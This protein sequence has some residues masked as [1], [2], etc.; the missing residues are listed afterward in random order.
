MTKLGK[1]F[2]S[3]FDQNKVR[4]RTF[5]LGGHTFKVLI[6]LTS[7]YEAMIE[8]IKVAD[9][10]S[11]EKYYAELTKEFVNN[12]DEIPEELGVVFTEDDVLIQNRSMR[13]AAKNKATTENRITEFF[14]LLVPEI[15]DFD[16]NSITYEDIDAEFPFSVQLQ[17]IEAISDT[18]SPNYK[19]IRGKSSGQSAGK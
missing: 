17:I 19:D 11:I 1:A 9:D 8:R 13:E 3:K 14:K 6:P 4:T 2:G 16:M 12:K 18:I 15:K 10:A 7:E 5:E